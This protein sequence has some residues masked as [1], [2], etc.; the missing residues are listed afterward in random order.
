MVHHKITVSFILCSSYLAF[1][2]AMPKPEGHTIEP[3]YIIQG[4]PP[5]PCKNNIC[6]QIKTAAPVKLEERSATVK[7]VDTGLPPPCKPINN[8]PVVGHEPRKIV[9]VVHP[10]LS[11]RQPPTHQTAPV[12][13][14]DTGLPPPC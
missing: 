14:G 7:C 1:G 10:D 13:C 3:R 9:P 5:P 2:L 4:Q 11:V 12:K 6:P 8:I